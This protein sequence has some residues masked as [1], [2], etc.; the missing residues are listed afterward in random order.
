MFSP[1]KLGRA[2]HDRLVVFDTQTLA[3]GRANH[4]VELSGRHETGV[5]YRVGYAKDAALRHAHGSIVGPIR[6]AHRQRTPAPP[7]KAPH[8]PPPNTPP[9]PPPSQPKPG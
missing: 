4:R 8:P 7:P 3:G 5:V 1:R 2:E 6:R 9:H